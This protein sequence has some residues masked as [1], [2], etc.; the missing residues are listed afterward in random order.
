MGRFFSFTLNSLAI[1]YRKRYAQSMFRTIIAC[2]FLACVAAGHAQVYRWTD[3]QGNLHFSDS[4]PESRDFEE[5]D[6]PPVL[7][8][9]AFKA[10]EQSAETSLDNEPDPKVYQR[11]RIIHPENDSAIRNNAG[12]LSVSLA[13]EPPLKG[14]HSIVLF[15]DGISVAEGRQSTFQLNNVDRGTHT[16][17]AEVRDSAGTTLLTT[18]PVEFSILRVSVLNK[19]AS[20]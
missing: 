12:D 3:E 14:N 16:L 13:M 20:F 15:M 1:M 5:V 11:F 7:S 10:P 2:T 18:D 9:P 4:P 6:I 17:H 8:V 19:P